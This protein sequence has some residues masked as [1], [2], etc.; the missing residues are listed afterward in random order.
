MDTVGN[1]EIGQ[2]MGPVLSLANLGILIPPLLGGLVYGWLGY[3]AVF[4]SMLAIVCLDITLRLVMVEKQNASK[5]MD[6][7][8]PNLPQDEDDQSQEEDP[9]LPSRPKTR[10]SQV[11]SLIGERKP[12]TPTIMIF[13]SQSRVL[14]DI[15][16]VLP[17]QTLITSFDGILSIF[18]YRTFG[19]GSTRAGLIILTVTVPILAAPLAGMLSDRYGPR[20]VTISGFILAACMYA[21][22]AL[23]THNDVGHVVLLC[24]LLTVLGK[25]RDVSYAQRIT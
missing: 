20:W 5:N 12:R 17:A 19:W 22:L 6:V 23:V 3:D 14:A 4:C 7:G 9:L 15:S 25:L 1:D 8:H 18:V 24:V 2:W 11:A 16:S 13:L 21:M 10:D